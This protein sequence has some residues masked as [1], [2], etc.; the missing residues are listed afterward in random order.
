MMR[1][2]VIGPRTAQSAPRIRPWAPLVLERRTVHWCEAQWEPE[3]F[4][5]P[6]IG[7]PARAIVVLAMDVLSWERHEHRWFEGRI[8]SCGLCLPHGV[9]MVGGPPLRVLVAPELRYAASG[10]MP[11][12]A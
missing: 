12:A 2:P 3:G 6:R 10:A 5:C 4:V 9:R 8:K 7:D 1:D 11:T